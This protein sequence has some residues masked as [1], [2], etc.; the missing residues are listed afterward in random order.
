MNINPPFL[1]MKNILKIFPWGKKRLYALQDINLSISNGETLGLVGESGCGKST[2][3]KVA[4]SLEKPT[5][6]TVLFK[7][8]D[9]QILAKHRLQLRREM[10][11]IFQDSYSALNPRKTILE[12]VAEGLDIHRLAVGTEREKKVA[13]LLDDVGLNSDLMS[14]YPY[15]LSGGQR[16]RVG[17]A[18]ALAVNPSFIVCDEPLSALDACT[19][20]QIL[21]LLLT[22]KQ[23]GL[24]YLF[25]SHDLHAVRVLSDTVA[26]MYLGRIVEYASAQ[27]LFVAPKHPYT[28][29]LLSAIPIADPIKE[30]QRNRLILTG[31][32]PSP[33]HSP[34]GCPFHPRCPKAVSLCRQ[35]LPPLTQLSQ[36]H[37]VACHL[38]L[39]MPLS[40]PLP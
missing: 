7:G 18:R 6:G 4:L 11:V 37:S 10:Q 35:S 9:L 36:S 12:C 23:K 33:L 17:I 29:A 31:D 22:L 5:S 15:E 1:M 16:Q 14:R 21:E 28:Q 40:M 8:Q 25:I 13:A 39:P 26:V 19:Q 38:A 32:P 34:Q 2:L 3:G 27:T 20:K 30:K 24:T